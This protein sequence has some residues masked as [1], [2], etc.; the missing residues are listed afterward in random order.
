MIEAT[1]AS[2]ANPNYIG[3]PPFNSQDPQW[4]QQK[5]VYT[6][7]NGKAFVRLFCV[8]SN[9]TVAAVARFDD[10][11]LQRSPG[12]TYGYTY[13]SAPWLNS[14]APNWGAPAGGTTRTIFGTGFLNGASVTVGGVPAT[15][16]VVAS[17]NNGIMFSVP[18]NSAG[19][20]DVVVTGPDGQK[21]NTLT[22]A[23]TYKTPPAAPAGMTNIHHIIYTFQ[24]NRSFDNYFGVMNQYRT[25]NGINDNAV[26]GLP[27]NVGLPD[28]TGNLILPF[29][30]QT[31][32]HENTAPNW[33]AS[34]LYY[35]GGKMDG[36]VRAQ[37]LFGLPS[38]IDPDATRAMGYYDY[39]DLPFYYS[40]AFQFATSDRWF[41][42]LM[43]PTGSNRAYTFAATSLGFLGTPQPP[44]GGFPN[45]TIFDLLDQAG[46]SWRYYYQNAKP[47][48]IPIWSV[49]FKDTNKVVPVSSYYTDVENESTFPQVVFIE[50]NGNQD[51]HPRPQPGMTGAGENIQN[52]AS[53]MSQII[54]ALMKSPSWTS[55]V[56]VLSYDEGGGLHDHVVPVSLPVPDAYPPRLNL[57]INQHG[58]FNQS[59]FRVPLVVISPW[60]TPHLVSHTPR[61]HTSILKLIEARF[62]LP[63][64]TSRDDAADNMLEFFNF[65]SPPYLT[66][67]ALASQPTNGVC[68]LNS[69][70]A[71]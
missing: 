16:V 58:M 47:L 27:L 21:S 64:L 32:C 43:G 26:D 54:T 55:S 51:E 48:W 46:V 44:I 65:S 40:L 49:Y 25:N 62:S 61:D 35:D 3:A 31:E 7:P 14:I 69:K 5:G 70:K 38:K 11:I 20:S 67:P 63:P 45:M 17:S 42:P 10:A 33:D 2:K 22:G 50:E 60:T 39:T 34:H 66:P 57:S 71:P 18:P 19:T 6:V 56:F 29:H 28:T 36:F 37:N 1:D 9:N 53:L 8:I 15:N 59:G 41:S 12:G 52:G 30:F 68:N 24:E 23:Y 13:V 4:V